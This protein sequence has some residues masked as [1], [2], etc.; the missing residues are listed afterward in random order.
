MTFELVHHA[1]AT[2]RTT[3]RYSLV[4]LVLIV[5]ATVTLAAQ[6]SAAPTDLPPE[7]NPA[8][9]PRIALRSRLL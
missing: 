2:R 3:A 5:L 6:R 4:S 8:S 7:K 1:R 9:A